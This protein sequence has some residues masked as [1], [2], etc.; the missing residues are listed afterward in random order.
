LFKT[1][2]YFRTRQEALEALSN[3]QVAPPAPK[4]EITLG[5]L[6][7]EWSEIKFPEIS[8]ATVNNYRA[9]WKYACKLEDIKF[10]ELRS[11]HW[12]NVIDS[13]KEE[14]L[15]RSSLK[16]IKTLATLLYGYA[17]QNDIVN[18]NYGEY[19]RLPKEEKKKKDIFTDLEI[20]EMFN[21]VNLIP[22]L[23]TILIMIYTGMR[24]SELLSLTRFNV[25]INKGVIVGGVK[26]DC[27][28][29]RVIPINKKILPYVQRWYDE[30][31]ESLI[32][33]KDGNPIPTKYYREKYYYSALKQAGIRQLKPHACRHTFASLMAQAKVDPLYIQRIIGHAD[34]AFTANEYTH[35]EIKVL[36]KAI[37]KI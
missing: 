32:C 5:D 27:G 7:K 22:W 17:L 25:D 28:K 36:E 15:S 2:G 29:D 37:N 34:Y 4:A 20:K 30:K 8:Q 35:P 13:C 26:T 24:I 31:G 3:Y 19:I 18:K 12:Q 14:G 6:Y 23:D 9:A 21:Q 33:R 1:I 16:K 11:G 10:K